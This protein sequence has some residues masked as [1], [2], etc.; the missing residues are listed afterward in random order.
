MAA[1]ASADSVNG[2]V[3][4]GAGHSEGIRMLNARRLQPSPALVISLIALFVSVSGVAWAVATV[5]TNDIKNGAV[6]KKKLHKN[7][8][9]TNKITGSA[10]T[11]GKIA[12]DAVGGAKIGDEAVGPSQLGP[13]TLRSASISVPAN[14]ARLISKNC[15][16]DELALSV[17]ANWNGA[18]TVGPVLQAATHL[19]GTPEPTGGSATGRNQGASARTLTV[20]VACL[21]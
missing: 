10:V 3:A 20:S 17:G 8:V 15:D 18:P 14:S 2:P 21:G 6:T 19:T 16:S 7:A 11:S 12:N 5:G 13:V 1:R 9:A 4:D